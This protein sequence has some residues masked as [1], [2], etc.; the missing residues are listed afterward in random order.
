MSERFF[1][2]RRAVWRYLFKEIGISPKEIGIFPL[3]IFDITLTL[4]QRPWNGPFSFKKMRTMKQFSLLLLSYFCCLAQCLAQETIEGRIVDA[5]TGEPLPYAKVYT[6]NKTGTLSNSDGYF[7]LAAHEGTKLKIT[8]IGYRQVECTAAEAR[9]MVRME[10][11]V[12]QMGQ[13][14]VLAYDM[15]DLVNQVIKELKNK[16]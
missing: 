16:E 13:V 8:Y 4:R 12:N 14:T 9:G 1:G 2:G 11:L 3:R 6:E 5:Q 7:R 10:P 15:S